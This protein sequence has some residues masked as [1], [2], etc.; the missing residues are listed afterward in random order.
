MKTTGASK[1]GLFLME[2][3]AVI[4]LFSVC[5]AVCLQLF[6]YA[7]VTAQNAENL[8]YG[9]MVSYSCAAC[10]QATDGD[11]QQMATLLEGKVDGDTVVVLYDQEW[12]P[13]TQVGC[14]QLL[15]VVSGT[16]ATITVVELGDT[17]AIFT[18]NVQ[19]KGGGAL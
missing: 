3:L 8:S 1:S 4:L 18:L 15:C 19:R 10:Y 17:E 11:L 2:L 14:Y 5:A 9:A 6:A 13:T 12:Q 7:N 16:T